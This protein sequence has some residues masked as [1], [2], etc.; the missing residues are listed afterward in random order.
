MP[1]AR[2]LK[3]MLLASALFFALASLVWLDG[4]NADVLLFAPLFVLVVPLL[5]G[6]YVGEET[7]ARLRRATAYAT[8]PRRAPGALGGPALTR[9]VLP[10]FRDRLVAGAHGCLPPPVLART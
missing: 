2:D 1:G 4:F 5:G 6:R 3:L 10:A 9:L 8:A 7:L